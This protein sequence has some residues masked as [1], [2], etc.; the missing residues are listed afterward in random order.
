MCSK[1]H[2]ANTHSQAWQAFPLIYLFEISVETDK[3]VALSVTNPP[4][5][6]SAS[7]PYKLSLLLP[8]GEFRGS[9]T[10]TGWEADHLSF[11]HSYADRFADKQ[12]RAMVQFLSKTM[13]ILPGTGS[14]ICP[15]R[16]INKGAAYCFHWCCKI[17]PDSLV[18]CFLMSLDM[19][20]QY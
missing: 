11:E 2:A 14:F 20:I 4:S 10:Q 15:C 18:C 7:P 5:Q 12:E 16:G 3:R 1:S 13:T 19:T 9:Q 8:L 6:L 17:I